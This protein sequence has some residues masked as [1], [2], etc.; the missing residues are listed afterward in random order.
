MENG[1]KH[2]SALEW[3]SI[4]MDMALMT[5][6][7]MHLLISSVEI[8]DMNFVVCAQHYNAAS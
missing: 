5:V 6:T 1:P 7:L 8:A 4:D 2:A 3:R